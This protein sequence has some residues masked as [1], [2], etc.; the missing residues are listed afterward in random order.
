MEKA[1]IVAWVIRAM[2]AWIPISAHSEAPE[3]VKARYE[4]LAND[5]HDVAI[6][7]SPLFKGDSEY[8]RTIILIAS[9]ESFESAFKKGAVGDKG[10]SFC[11]MQIQPG[12]NGI[13]LDGDEW[14]YGRVDDAYVLR[15][16]DL[17]SDHKACVRAGLHMLR[18]S[19]RHTG[20]LGEYTGEGRGGKKAKHRMTR[21]EWYFRNKKS[22][23]ETK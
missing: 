21:A 11:E 7:E 3:D 9:V 6:S 12:R 20:D 13:V 8:L 10:R 18:A 5:Y 4:E 22:E 23:L 17:L 1:T 14:R 19:L 15:G 16:Q 2:T